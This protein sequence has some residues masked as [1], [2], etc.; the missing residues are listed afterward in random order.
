M[1]KYHIGKSS[2]RTWAK[3]FGT[4]RLWERQ[5]KGACDFKTDWLAVEV[6]VKKIPLF[7]KKELQQ[8]IRDSEFGKLLPVAI[9]HE[10]DKSYDEDLIVMRA[11][12]FMRWFG[13]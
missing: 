8:A 12:D 7:L 11:I 10:K 2:E 6:F 5:S 9:W 3:K 13:N 4:K 1:S